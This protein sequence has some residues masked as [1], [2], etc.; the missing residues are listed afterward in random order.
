MSAIDFNSFIAFCR[1]LEGQT[2]PTIGGRAQFVL[3]SVR[4]DGLY[5][6]VL[7]TLKVR[8]ASRRYIAHVLKQYRMTN[9]LRPV[10]YQHITLNASYT[11]SL[12]KLYLKQQPK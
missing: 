4:S 2:L 12:I 6:T 10:D 1:S 7:S 8:K 11:L 3:S 5:Y 9:S